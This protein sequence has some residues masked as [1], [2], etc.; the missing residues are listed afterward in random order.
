MG[1]CFRL[2]VAFGLIG[3]AWQPSAMAQSSGVVASFS[4]L[5][6]G[7]SVLLAAVS[8]VFVMIKIARLIDVLI[9]RF[10]KD[11]ASSGR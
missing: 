5:L 9:E 1:F 6:I 7:V 11:S 8:F 4:N 2:V 3:L 10:D